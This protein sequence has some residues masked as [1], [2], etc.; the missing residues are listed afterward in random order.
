M[1][2][3]VMPFQIDFDMVTGKSTSEIYKPTLRRVS[4]MRDQFADTNAADKLIADGDPILY[5]FY[6]MGMP[7]LPGDLQFGTSIV[8]PGKVG[9]EYNMTKGHFHII[10]ETAEVYYCMGGEGIMLMETPEGEVRYEKM[11]KGSCVYVAPRWA[12]RSICT[13][14]DEPLL[15][16][17]CFRGDAGHD[18][19][20]IETK[21]YRKLVVEKDGKPEL[22][23]N[24]KWK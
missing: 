8:Y 10:L 5:E 24:P 17:F 11:V 16:F 15:M 7:E 19:G 6:E 1:N 4:N 18:Y 22:I 21:G 2:D 14:Q 3:K 23:D 12:H 20:T 13:S 9:N